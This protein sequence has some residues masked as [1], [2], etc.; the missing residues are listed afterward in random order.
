MADIRSDRPFIIGTSK[1][2]ILQGHN[3]L[4]PGSGRLW[5]R[6]FAILQFAPFLH[7]IRHEQLNSPPI[8]A[9]I[10]TA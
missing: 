8:S 6:Q 3:G 10:A 5:R 9:D 4:E 1:N 7:S 2:D